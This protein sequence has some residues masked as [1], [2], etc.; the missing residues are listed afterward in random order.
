MRHVFVNKRKQFDRQY[1]KEKRKY[2]S[3]YQ[4]KLCELKT[5]DPKKFWNEISNLGP[6]SKKSRIPKDVILEDGKITTD[7][8]EILQKWEKDH[9]ELFASNTAE[10]SESGNFVNRV[11]ETLNIWNKDYRGLLTSMNITS[12]D[13]NHGYI[14]TDNLNRDNTNL[15][16]EKALKLARNGK[17]VG[18]DNLPNDILKCLHVKDVLHS[19]YNKCF[20]YGI[21]PNIWSQTLWYPIV[22][23]GKDPRI[24][25]NCCGISLISTVSKLF[26]TILN[27]RL[28][29]FIDNNNILCEE[30]N[31]FRKARSCTEH[32]YIMSTIIRK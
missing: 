9:R 22:K 24:P 1:R 16:V 10:N 20:Q 14:A 5:N 19:L 12:D 28:V 26:S 15:Q 8:G 3:G 21:V 2:L 32:I 6:K 18:I 27:A 7:I 29:N 11:K 4:A 25:T 13:S 23:P 31:G 17:A 30:Q